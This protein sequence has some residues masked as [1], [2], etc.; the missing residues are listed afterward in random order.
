MENKDDVV[1]A[2]RVYRWGYYFSTVL[3][4]AVIIGYSIIN[5]MYKPS[6]KLV[7][8]T[9]VNSVYLNEDLTQTTST[10]G[11]LKQW[12]YETLQ[13]TFT[14]D[15]LSF[16]PPDAYAKTVNGELYTDLPDHR[17]KIRAFFND[18]A[19]GKIISS[20][21]EAPWSFRF[22]EERR[23]LNFSMTTP[24]TTRGTA[25][26]FKVEN[27]RLVRDFNG[28]FYIISQG[29]K[30]KDARYRID[31]T[32]TIERRP[33]ATKQDAKN[34]FFRPMAPDNNTEWRIK[35]LGWSAKRVN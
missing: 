15:Y 8:L 21:E 30:R 11:E 3:I 10:E 17:D 5:V 34:Y 32:V 6:D 16:L 18:E 2:V 26:D 4:L 31:F 9:H 1:G 22:T 28:Y 7:L 35:D 24:P 27:G 13:S 19:L 14:Y 25:S 23:R 33:N 20:L 12:V 29:F